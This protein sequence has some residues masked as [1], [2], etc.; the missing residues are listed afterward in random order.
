MSWNSDAREHLE[1][2]GVELLENRGHVEAIHEQRLPALALRVRQQVEELQACWV[3]LRGTYTSAQRKIR[4][5][6]DGM[7]HVV[8]VVGVRFQGEVRVRRV[9]VLQVRGKIPETAVLGLADEGDASAEFFG[10]FR[11]RRHALDEAEPKLVLDVVRAEAF[12]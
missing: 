12:I 9:A 7:T 5:R 1:R 8:G 3:G 10:I 4:G 6:G 2:I 11:R